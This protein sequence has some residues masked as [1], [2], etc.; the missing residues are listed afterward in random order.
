MDPRLEVRSNEAGFSV[1]EGLIAAALLL[2]VTLGV[3]PLFT[4]SMANN[5]RGNVSTRQ[6]NGTV[7]EF[8][9]LTA[10]P[11][12]AGDTSLL[13]GNSR[14]TDTVI[15]L[16]QLPGNPTGALSYRWEPA[17]TLPPGDRVDTLR[18]STL[19]QFPFHDFNFQEPESSLLNPEPVTAEER[20]IHLKVI[21]VEFFD[22]IR[23]PSLA[24]PDY[25]VRLYKV[26]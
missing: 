11:L 9:R 4:R 14:V 21:D 10:L 17:A 15:A 19:R 24:D 5:L 22:P 2:I 18:R 8:E 26:F 13:A 12:N 6:A 7:D 3:L 16:K 20:N 1:I 25:E 23:D